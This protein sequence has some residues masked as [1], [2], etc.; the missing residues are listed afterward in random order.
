MKHLIF[1]G[2]SIIN[3]AFY[4]IRMLTTKEGVP[5]NAVFGFINIFQKAV[6][7]EKPDC[8]C[9]AFDLPKKTFRHEQYEKYK[10]QR[11]GMPDELAAQMP[12]LKE[13]LDLSGVPRLE[14]AGYE[15]DDIIGTLAKQCEQ[16][17][18]E[19]II[20]T[21]DRDDL[22]LVSDKV[23]VRFAV[24]RTGGSE[25]IM[26]TP[27]KVKEEYGFAPQQMID[28]KAIAG[29]SSDNIPGVAG[30][31]DK[32]A[33]MLVS[34][35]GS[36]ENIYQNID[37][38]SIKKGMREKL[39]ASKEI[40]ELSLSLATICCE[41]PLPENL[42]DLS[43]KTQNTKGLIKFYQQYEMKKM[44]LKLQDNDETESKGKVILEIPEAEE[45]LSPLSAATISSERIYLDYSENGLAIFD[46]EQI[47]FALADN[48]N[49]F[50]IAKAIFALP[51]KWI[52]HDSKSAMVRARKSGLP[53]PSIAFDSYLAAY[54]ENASAK[55]YD[56]PLLALEYLG[57]E[58]KDEMTERVYAL[59]KLASVLEESLK[60]KEMW[61]LFSEIELPLAE[62]LGEME[63]VGMRIDAEALKE[64]GEN[65]AKELTELEGKI[66]ELSGCEFNIGSPKQLGEV[67]FERLGLPT[68]KKTKTGYST[69]A[70][71]LERLRKY[72]P[73]IEYILQYR[74]VSKLKSTYADGLLKVYDKEDGRIHTTF[75]QTVTQTGR[76]SSTEP[77]LQNIPVRGEQ[78][79]EIRRLFIPAEGHILLDAD[80]SQIEL[81]VLAHIAG[82]KTMIEAFKSGEDIHT[83][84]ASQVFGVPHESVTAE[85]R[86]KAKAV[87]FGIVY[88]ISD[89]SLASDIGVSRKEAGEYIAG[90]FANYPEIKEYLDRTVEEAREKG[91]VTTMFG[92]RRYLPEIKS[93]NYNIRSFGERVAMN[94]PIQGAAADIIKIAM[95]RVAKALK[96]AKLS[97]KLILQVH[98]ELIVEAPL[99]E[100]D[101]AAEILHREMEA[102]AELLAPLEAEVHRGDSWLSAK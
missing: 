66:H 85:L 84:T 75:N 61:E 63:L 29:D 32:G 83:V 95:V 42:K 59:S 98:D 18:E 70:E 79:R 40:A 43:L 4:G 25:S 55:S 74:M 47:C 11:K 34:Q 81:R 82:D 97:A 78:G 39:I 53:F 51:S 68:G 62:V 35:F 48:E 92:R 23:V 76:I 5:T 44:L 88:G 1:D 16:E 45:L 21:G 99:D 101:K 28:Y 71:V 94:T 8:I 6:E 2:N 9:V 46:G 31:G 7:E 49:F 64:Y 77:N 26:Y 27:E 14:L 52:I 10:A 13:W 22:Q 80:Y 73:V 65:L 19:C 58:I 17:G 41:V 93:S 72:H 102:A 87:N 86:R 15:A 69:G 3:R 12:M 91:F 33:R 90:Y 20:V 96:K 57:A 36:L 24:T 60:E 50:E 100:A 89:F 30:I 56:V 37:D 67:L 54:L 38:P